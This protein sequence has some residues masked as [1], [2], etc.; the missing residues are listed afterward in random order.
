V[1]EDDL[2]TA[3][4]REYVHS[5]PWPK[6]LIMDIAYNDDPLP[7]LNFIFYRDNWLEFDFTQQAKIAALIQEVITKLRN[8][9]VPAYMGRMENAPR[10]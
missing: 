8:D 7:H 4:V 6:G 1:E 3:E 10:A 5:R 2:Y 9:G